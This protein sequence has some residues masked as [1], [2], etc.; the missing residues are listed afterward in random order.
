MLALYSSL[1]P[2][3]ST[4]NAC[5]LSWCDYDPHRA[6][7]LTVGDAWEKGSKGRQ[8]HTWGI[9][10]VIITARQLSFMPI[11]NLN[12]GVHGGERGLGCGH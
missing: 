3:I 7:G 2:V 4:D 10:E 9:W 5:G 8:D 1:C 12:S 6:N 11:V